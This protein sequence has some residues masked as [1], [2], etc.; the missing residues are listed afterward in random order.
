M[1]IAVANTNRVIIRGLVVASGM[2]NMAARGGFSVKGR[3]VV[4]VARLLVLAL[5][6]VAG[7]VAL[8]VSPVIPVGVVALVGVVG[9]AM[10]HGGGAAARKSLVAMCVVRL[11]CSWPSGQCTVIKSFRKSPNVAIMSG[12]QALVRS[13]QRYNCWKMRA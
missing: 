12:G 4:V 2:A 1:V 11:Y 6:G 9:M 3:M 10:G 8:V 7:V 5:V 13:T